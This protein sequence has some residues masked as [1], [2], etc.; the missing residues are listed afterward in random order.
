MAFS[1]MTVWRKFWKWLPRMLFYLFISSFI[2][3]VLCR[4][5]MP[6]ITIMQ[7]TNAWGIGF[8]RDYVSWEQISPAVKLAAIASEDQSFT[9]HGGFDWDAILQSLRNSKYG[10]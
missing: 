3:I 10:N 5:I 4:F 6:P 7:I 8:K 2:Y 9:D 1:L